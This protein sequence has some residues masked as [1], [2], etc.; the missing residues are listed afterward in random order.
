MSLV[1]TTY[2]V[3]HSDIHMARKAR[4]ARMARSHSTELSSE[5]CV[6]W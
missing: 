4:K 1:A 2:P 5:L 3:Y 6:S